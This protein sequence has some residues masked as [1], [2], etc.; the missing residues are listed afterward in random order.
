M[1]NEERLK[2]L[3]KIARLLNSSGITWAVGG[4]LLLYFKKKTDIF[5]DI[6]IMV[7]E[8]DAERL[9]TLLEPLGTLEKPKENGQYQTKYFWEFTIDGAEVDVMGGFGIVK[10]GKVWDCSLKPESIEEYQNLGG[11]QIPL[12]SLEEWKRYYYLMDRE[13]KVRMIEGRR[14]TPFL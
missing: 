13:E 7:A 14:K 1:S 11:E 6:D 4:S 9:K 5:H 2:V 10:D 12:H 8:E 3:V